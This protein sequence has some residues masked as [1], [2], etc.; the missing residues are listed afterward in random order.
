MRIRSRKALAWIL[1]LT[2]LLLGLA[3][4]GGASVSDESGAPLAELTIPVG[5]LGDRVEYAGY[6]NETD[7][8]ENSQTDEDI[9]W[10]IEFDG[11]RRTMSAA[12]ET[13]DVLVAHERFT[14]DGWPESHGWTSNL[15]LASRR[16]VRTD[17]LVEDLT[18]P[19]PFYWAYSQFFRTSG[20]FEEY[21]GWQGQNLR[22]GQSIPVEVC[23]NAEFPDLHRSVRRW[24]SDTAWID[25]QPAIALR[26]EETYYDGGH[27]FQGTSTWVLWFVANNP[28]PVMIEEWD[29]F[30]DWE[31]GHPEGATKWTSHDVY[32]QQ[33]Y[34]PAGSPVPW[35]PGENDPCA[36]AAL[37]ST[38]RGSGPI[39]SDGDASLWPYP[40][41]QAIRDIETSPAFILWTTQHPGAKLIGFELFP[42][43]SRSEAAIEEGFGLWVVTF[44]EGTSA[45]SVSTERARPQA[46]P[47]VRVR[48]EAVLDRDPQPELPNNVITLGHVQR[49]WGEEQASCRGVSPSLAWGFYWLEP[50][51]LVS[52]F[53][54]T[55]ITI[56]CRTNPL[57]PVQVVTG[58]DQFTE[59]SMTVSLLTGA[60]LRKDQSMFTIFSILPVP[61]LPAGKPPPDLRAHQVNVGSV[62]APDVIVWISSSLAIL[63]FLALLVKA[64]TSGLL[65]GY[66]KIRGDQLL[67]HPMRDTIRAHIS[68]NP[69][70]SP[71]RL[72]QSIGVPWST[73]TYHLS[74]LERDRLVSSRV[75]G[76]HKYLFVP[77][78]GSDSDRERL[79][80]LQNVRT[81]TVLEGIQRSPGINQLALAR[82]FGL[83]PKTITWHLRRLAS[84]NLVRS[85]SRGRGN[86]WFAEAQPA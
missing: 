69:G 81:R 65:P 4:V 9:A 18:G 33:K 32:Y 29:E 5:G 67:E 15:D 56:S 72:Q 11:T 12:G 27:S 21:Y 41:S 43:T 52:N 40:L 59:N 39:P 51:Y 10:A 58:G 42:L 37:P 3:A 75:R 53:D 64:L 34:E 36:D 2:F 47:I 80:I 19:R 55:S 45:V 48:E 25:G 49:M 66:A 85:E 68:Q 82:Q 26:T 50:L 31:P 54:F 78:A 76:R 38:P 28:Y 63:L 16:V 71:P 77:E 20:S 13:L 70:I 17:H 30:L 6:S 79:T 57:D 60:I 14:V 62:S 61:A 23:G 7:T 84:V 73:L 22:L 46:P 8:A 74:V 35:E 24:V 83:D 1:I 44:A 86:A